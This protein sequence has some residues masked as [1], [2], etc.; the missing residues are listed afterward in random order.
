MPEVAVGPLGD[1]TEPLSE[2]NVTPLVD[3]ML[4]LLVI[5]IILAPLMAQALRV[6]LPRADAPVVAEPVVAD[7]VLRQDGA[8]EL[9]GAALER[10]ALRERLRARKAQAPELVVRLGVDGAARYQELAELLSLLHQA[11][12]QRIA[13]ATRAL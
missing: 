12:I 5:F 7:L 2:I 1:H 3:V 13:F 9:D 8:L 10:E 6:D 4:V 11:D